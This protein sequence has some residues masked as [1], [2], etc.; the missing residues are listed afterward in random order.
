M[1]GGSPVIYSVGHSDRDPG[2][3]ECTAIDNTDAAP[4]ALCPRK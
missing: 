2:D 3:P 1:S 4:A